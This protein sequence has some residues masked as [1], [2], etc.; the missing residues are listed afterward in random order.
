M[1]SFGYDE[2][3]QWYVMRDLKR[4]NAKL[5]A[6]K[7]LERNKVKVFVPM[8][9]RLVMKRGKYVREKV[10][11][12][13]DLLFVHESRSKLDP[14][15]NK[16]PTLQYRWLRNTWRTPTTVPDAD[17]ERFMLAVNA[18]ESPEYYLLEEVTP[19][20]YGRKICIIGGPLDGY[21]GHLITKRGSKVKYLLVELKGYLSVSVEVDPEYIQIIK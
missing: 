13:Q 17:M 3:V 9:W 15:V 5:P 8:S 11:F 16:T 7:L 1:C 19:N 14:I 2:K 21:E 4:S 12:I 10:P 6:Y 20:M 18:S